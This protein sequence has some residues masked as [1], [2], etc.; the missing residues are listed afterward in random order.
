MANLCRL[1]EKLIAA[2]KARD[3]QILV[4][5]NAQSCSQ[6]NHNLLYCYRHLP[7]D[8]EVMAFADSDA[9]LRG[10]WLASIVYPLRKDKVGRCH[11]LPL[12]YSAEK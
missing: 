6:K 10:N 3:V 4:A 7:A 5:G 2:T 12:V 11:R 9:C 1:K 8:I